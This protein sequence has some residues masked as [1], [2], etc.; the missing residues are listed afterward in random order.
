VSYGPNQAALSGADELTGYA[1]GPP[2]ISTSTYADFCAGYTGALAILAALEDR[3]RTG[4]G[5][6]VDMSQFAAVVSML[7]PLLLDVERSG[8]V[9]Q[10]AGNHSAA[11]A[12]RGV[13]PC[14]GTD[15]WCGIEVRTDDEFR[16]L[17]AAAGRADWLADQRF[18]TVPARQDHRDELDGEIASWTRQHAPEEV[19]AWLQE[20]S[21]PAFA[22]LD[23]ADVLRDGHVAGRGRW[24]FP[25]HARFGPDMTTQEAPQLSQTSG[26]FDRAGPALGQDTDY[27]LGQLCGYTAADIDALV[28][29]GV[30]SRLAEPERT[31]TRPYL[32]WAPGLLHN[33]AWPAPPPER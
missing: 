3:D 25:P 15:A 23:V 11:A 24:A 16:S 20:R 31:L 14:R 21:V 5:Q 26:S 29:A 8:H 10:R 13:Y 30:T 28:Q 33:I 22:L 4:H 6:L 9:P 17:A 32:A 27:V 19:A 7:G 12:P 2:A 1:E 18:A